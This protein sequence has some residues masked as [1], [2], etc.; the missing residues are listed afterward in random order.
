MQEAVRTLR[1][2]VQHRATN[3]Q[4]HYEYQ[5]FMQELL[6]TYKQATPHKSDILFTVYHFVLQ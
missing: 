5:Q 1:R 2:G 3:F 6:N 4:S